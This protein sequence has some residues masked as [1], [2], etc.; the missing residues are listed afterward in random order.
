MSQD[1][2]YYMARAAEERRL[3]MASTDVRARRAHL[4]MAAQYAL[5][6]RPFGSKTA[7]WRSSDGEEATG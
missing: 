3:A 7:H 1:T 2:S 5:K 4:E 6:S